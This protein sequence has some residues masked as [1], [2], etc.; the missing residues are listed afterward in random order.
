MHVESTYPLH[1]IV[2][3]LVYFFY[4]HHHMTQ[5]A[6]LSALSPPSLLYKAK[7]DLTCV[8]NEA[9]SSRRTEPVVLVKNKETN[10]H[11][12]EADRLL[13]KAVDTQGKTSFGEGWCE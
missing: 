2:N 7:Y 6:W 12:K 10:S 4:Q 3:V 5:Y 13:V 8:E 9:S 1:V 11:P